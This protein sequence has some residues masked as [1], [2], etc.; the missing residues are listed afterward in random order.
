M[1]LLFKTMILTIGMQWHTMMEIVPKK[2]TLTVVE[3]GKEGEVIPREKIATIMVRLTKNHLSEINPQTL[4][5][6]KAQDCGTG[7]QKGN[8]EVCFFV[9][10]YGTVRDESRV[11]P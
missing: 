1:F 4:S 11:E 3:V 10:P 7:T 9:S 5:Q 8:P 6:K 2:T